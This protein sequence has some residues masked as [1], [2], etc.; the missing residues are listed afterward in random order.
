MQ[1]IF[2]DKAAVL[3][4]RISHIIFIIITYN[5]TVCGSACTRASNLTDLSVKIRSFCSKYRVRIWPLII[6]IYGKARATV[7]R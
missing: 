1:H 6:R 2:G 7:P 4:L 5:I 3:V